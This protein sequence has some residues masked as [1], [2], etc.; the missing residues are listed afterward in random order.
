MD[1]PQARRAECRRLEGV[2]VY[3]ALVRHAA[4]VPVP[5]VDSRRA[6]LAEQATDGA[7]ALPAGDD[8]AGERARIEILC[9]LHDRRA[10]AK[11]VP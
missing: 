10:R 1:A 9:A 4:A 6:V 2:A 8:L 3:G 5:R 7:I 11:H